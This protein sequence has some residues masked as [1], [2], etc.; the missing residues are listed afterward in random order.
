MAY[1]RSGGKLV[2]EVPNTADRESLQDSQLQL[3]NPPGRISLDEAAAKPKQQG[4]QGF[5]H[6]LLSELM[7][8]EATSAYRAL[9]AAN[10]AD[11]KLQ[12]LNQLL[13][14]DAVIRQA[15]ERIE[16]EYLTCMDCSHHYYVNGEVK[17][18]PCSCGCRLFVVGR[19][20]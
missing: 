2:S 18:E 20:H 14:S 17:L 13:L 4:S 1:Q 5:W 7:Y 6:E 9:Q 19:H 10:P 3:K 16:D 12:E 15:G 8:L 11:V